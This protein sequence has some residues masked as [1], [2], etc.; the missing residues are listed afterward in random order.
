[1]S[2]P[3]SA[4]PATPGFSGKVALITGAAG[5]IGAAVAQRLARAGARVVLADKNREG[6]AR[7]TA[8]LVD[9]GLSAVAVE[10]DQTSSEQVE[11][12]FREHLADGLD[13]CF[14]NAGWGRTDAFIDMPLDTLRRTFDINVFGTVMVCQAAARA[15]IAGKRGGSIILTSSTGAQQAAA[16][17]GAYCAAKASLNMLARVMALELGAYDIRVNTVMPGVTATAMTSSLLKTNAK[18]LCEFEAPLGRIGR[19][20]DI[21]GAVA[22]LAG[23]DSGYITGTSLLIDGGST[24]NATQWFSTDYRERG[25]VDWKLRSE[26]VVL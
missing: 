3:P 10:C 22:F 9:S 4:S 21:A 15:M 8:A 12:L 20:E 23:E 1:M 24:Q 5:D 16:L 26:R 17:F 7:V 6:L 11:A 2:A 25:R 14:A 18:D 13:I 19:P